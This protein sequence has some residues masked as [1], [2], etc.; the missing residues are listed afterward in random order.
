V[1]KSLLLLESRAANEEIGGNESSIGNPSGNDFE[2]SAWFSVADGGLNSEGLL[3][4]ADELFCNG[5]IRPLRLPPRLQRPVKAA[6]PGID[7][8][9]PNKRGVPF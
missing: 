1:E 8:N 3:S 4:R 2:F 7:F 5:Q 6:A 9:D